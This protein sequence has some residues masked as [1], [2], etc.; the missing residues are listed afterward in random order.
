MKQGYLNKI[1]YHLACGNDEKVEYFF[2][3]Q[4]QVYGPITS[5]QMKHI[6]ETRDDI[7]KEWEMEMNEFNAHIG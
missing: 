3:R 1:A 4:V 2:N 5:F 6:T 7:V